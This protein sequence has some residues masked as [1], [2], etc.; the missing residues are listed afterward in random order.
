MGFL[1]TL[2]K[3]APIESGPWWFSRQYVLNQL[4]SIKVKPGDIICRLGNAYVYGYIWFSK[5][6]S[7]VTKSDY[8]HAAMVCDVTEDDILL[9]D[10]NTSG[11]RR[12]FVTDWCDD[13]RGDHIAV[14]RFKGDE[15]ISQCAVEE[16]KSIFRIDPR[17]EN[18][19]L[20][21]DDGRN[22]YCVELVCWCYRKC[23]IVLCEEVKICEL[24][25]WRKW[26]TAMSVLHGVDVN[27]KIMCVG[28]S[29]IGLLSSS[30]LD[31]VGKIRLPPFSKPKFINNTL[32]FRGA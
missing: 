5:F 20:D 10:V 19:L 11:L 32:D 31:L 4:K 14:L 18:E 27:K 21:S 26:M 2:R 28:N 17:H 15:K 25:G 23:G 3:L 6:I 8:S 12:Q 29:K 9:A 1:N 30:H 13:I 7:T 24:P 22:F 16:I